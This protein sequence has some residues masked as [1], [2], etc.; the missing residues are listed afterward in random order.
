[1]EMVKG[2]RTAHAAAVNSLFVC[3]EAGLVIGLD[4]DTIKI[5]DTVK[6]VELNV[7]RSEN[8]DDSIVPGLNAIFRA[9]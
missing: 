4:E 8:N 9:V 2:L 5:W 3:F 1:M 7:Y 6:G